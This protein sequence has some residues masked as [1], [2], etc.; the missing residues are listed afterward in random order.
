MGIKKVS[1]DTSQKQPA[2]YRVLALDQSSRVTG[3]AL[4]EVKNKKV[5]LLAVGIIDIFKDENN[6]EVSLYDRVAILGHKVQALIDQTKPD[7]LA[8]EKPFVGQNRNTAFA[9]FCCFGAVL[10]CAAQNGL[11]VYDVTPA[12]AKSFVLKGTNWKGKDSKVMVKKVLSE[13]FGIS[14]TSPKDTICD[15]SDAAAVGLT[16]ISKY[17]T[18]DKNKKP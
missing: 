3:W 7:V 12:E 5:F 8:M 15:D 11:K 13:Q 16:V 2:N 1:T 17:F 9:L 6:K 14:F 4:L 10:L 18:L